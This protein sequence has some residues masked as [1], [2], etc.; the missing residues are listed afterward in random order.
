MSF[1]LQSDNAPSCRRPHTMRAP[2]TSCGNT[3]G[4]LEWRH[5]QACVFCAT[6]GRWNYNAAKTETLQDQRL[7]RIEREWLTA[8][9]D[10]E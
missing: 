3:N 6:C 9:D 8:A 10:E 2:C 5:G 7:D 1:Q 4:Y